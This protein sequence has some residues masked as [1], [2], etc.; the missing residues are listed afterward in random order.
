MSSQARG[1]KD[2]VGVL[3]EFFIWNSFL[4]GNLATV[5]ND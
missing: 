4:D 2:S 3:F 5:R 1:E